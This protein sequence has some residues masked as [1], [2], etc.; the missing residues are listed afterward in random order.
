MPAWLPLVRSGHPSRR[1]PAPRSPTAAEFPGCRP[2]HLPREELDD[3]E[4]KLEYWDAASETAWICDPDSSY[5]EGP[6]RRVGKLTERIA[7]VRG[8][9]VECLGCTDLTE[10]DAHGEPR[11]IMQADE[12]VYLHPACAKLPRPVLTSRRA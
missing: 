6:T 7:A 8:T 11:L 12:M 10:R 3:C 4:I 5:H 2:V 9:P 1:R